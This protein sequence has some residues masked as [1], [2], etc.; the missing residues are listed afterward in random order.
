M[1]WLSR[2]T[3]DRGLPKAVRWGPR[4]I[5]PRAR[6]VNSPRTTFP[7]E[8]SGRLCCARCQRR[9]QLGSG[10]AVDPQDLGIAGGAVPD[11]RATETNALDGLELR[12]TIGP[13]VG[14]LCAGSG[15]PGHAVPEAVRRIAHLER[16]HI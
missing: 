1:A 11:D 6:D 9:S 4:S 13:A 16:R 14:V 3:A 5:E 12:E 10:S 7:G 2:A 15:C 8:G